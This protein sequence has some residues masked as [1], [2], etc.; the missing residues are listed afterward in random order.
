MNSFGIIGILIGITCTTLAFLVYLQDRKK[1]TNYLWFIFALSVA[2]WGFGSCVISLTQNPGISILWWH[3]SH[4]GVIIIP[5]SFLVFTYSFLAKDLRKVSIIAIVGSIFFLILDATPYLLGP[6][7][8]VF[9]SF[10]YSEATKPFYSALVATFILLIT[11]SLYKVYEEYLKTSDRIRKQQILCFGLASIIGFVGGSMSFL[12][13]YGIMIYPYGNACII[14]FSFIIAYSIAKH[15]LF[16]TKIISAE[17]VTFGLW[18]FILTRTILAVSIRD[19]IIQG[20]LLLITVIFGIM[21]IR[22]V[23]KESRQKE[24]LANLN[25]H[26]SDKVAEQTVEIRKAYELEKKARREL[27][28]LNETKDQFI[29]ITQHHLRTPV[30]S[31]RWGIEETLKGSYGKIPAKVHVT[32]EDTG[33]AVGRLMRIVDDFLSITALK[34]GSQILTI[35]P[36]S[37][38]PLLEDILHELR[39]DIEAKQIAISYPKDPSSWPELPIDAPKIRETVLIVIE[40]A[41]RYNVQGGSV[42]IATRIHDAMFEMTVRNTGIGITPEEREKLF[43]S[44]FYRGESARSAHPIGMGVGLSVSRAIVRAHHGELTIESEGRDEGALATLRI[45]LTRETEHRD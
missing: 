45:P 42:D 8:Y 25:L 36:A 39:I 31:I 18:T 14:I 43:T 33:K 5:F 12:P 24:E 10:Y 38:L 34:V 4:I 35:S 26:L 21:L 15:H 3:L 23:L 13:A 28:K 1:P 9:N 17:I 29:M 40:N 7:R 30:T 32:L 22:S 27:E 44:L 2:I 6:A 11:F 41:V 37:L 19:F 16:N 20:S